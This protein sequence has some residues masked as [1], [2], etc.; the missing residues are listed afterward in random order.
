VKHEHRLAEWRPSV[1]ERHVLVVKGDDRELRQHHGVGE[2]IVTNRNFEHRPRLEQDS[3][4]SAS[5]LD[6]RAYSKPN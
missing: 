2:V 1:A 4:V 3:Q 5:S 6:L